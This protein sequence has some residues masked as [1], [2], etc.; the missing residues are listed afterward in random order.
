MIQCYFLLQIQT[1]VQ[2]ESTI[3]TAVPL[4]VTPKDSSY[5]LIAQVMDEV[6]PKKRT[7]G[8]TITHILL[9]NIRHL[10]KCSAQ[11]SLHWEKW[12]LF[13]RLYLYS[14]RKFQG[15][16]YSLL[17]FYNAQQEGIPF[18]F[19]TVKER[20]CSLRL[21]QAACTKN[22]RIR[23]SLPARLGLLQSGAGI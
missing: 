13:Q 3:V 19:F 8:N 21:D 9:F 2:Q 7:T 4:A 11:L 22:C 12:Q 6:L 16:S 10:Y 23:E 5:A 17:L 15:L 14:K 18:F 1:N 20:L